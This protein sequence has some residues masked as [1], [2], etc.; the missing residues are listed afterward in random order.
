MVDA[1]AGAQQRLDAFAARGAAT[2]TTVAVGDVAM[3][4]PAQSVPLDHAAIAW[5]HASGV[6]A[7]PNPATLAAEMVVTDTGLAYTTFPVPYVWWRAWGDVVCSMAAVGRPRWGQRTVSVF[8]ADR[9]PP[10]EGRAFELPRGAAKAFMDF[11]V[12][13]AAVPPQAPS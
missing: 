8:V 13:R 1:L 3:V 10:F 12:Q 7:P 9:V 4:F 5:A 2:G 11:A 6:P